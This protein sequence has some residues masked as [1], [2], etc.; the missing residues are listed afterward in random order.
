ME[1]N[2]EVSLLH[3]LLKISNADKI[4]IDSNGKMMAINNKLWSK[5]IRVEKLFNPEVIEEGHTTITKEIVN[6]MPK[7]GEVTLTEDTIK[8]GKRK[9]EFTPID[10]IFEETDYINKI[11]TQLDKEIMD[12]LLE[13]DYAA[14]KEETRPILHGVHFKNGEVCALDGFRLSLRKSDKLQMDLEFTMPLEAIKIFKKIKSKEDVI[15]SCNEGCNIIKIQCGN[16]VIVSK[17]LEGKF[18]NYNQL[19][20]I[21]STTEIRLD[22]NEIKELYSILKSYGRDEKA[23]KLTIKENE[24]YISAKFPNNLLTINDAIICNTK[25]K[26]LEIGVNY[27]YLKEALDKK[28]KV[29]LCFQREVM[30][31]IIKEIT[32]LGEKI[33]LVLPI[34]LKKEEN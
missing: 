10:C 22:K 8:C 33:E 17:L 3:E 23:I 11:L 5:D 27:K 24:I 9:I 31:I 1:I 26:D 2:F 34:R 21:E 30:P 7:T 15:I 14:S 29:T 32:N 4:F 12:F 28:E 25:G 18:M 13:V 6:L 20:P 19:I 16:D